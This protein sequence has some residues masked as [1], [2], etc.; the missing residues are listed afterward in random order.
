MLALQGS[1]VS[2]QLWGTKWRTDEKATRSLPLPDGNCLVDPSTS[3]SIDRRTH[4]HHTRTHAH[5]HARVR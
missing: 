2:Q 4:T 3:N 5:T 1:E